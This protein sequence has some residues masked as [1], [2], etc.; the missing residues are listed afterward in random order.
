MLT[1]D[2][3]QIQVDD[4]GYLENLADWQPEVAEQIARE[5]GLELTEAHWEIL[6]LLRQFY[7]EFE[8]SPAMRPLVKYIGINL[9][10][11]KA[12]S[13]YLMQLF[14]ESPAKMASKLA[15]L[16]KPTNCL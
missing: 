14:G 4:E 9:D 2:N 13:I 1:I 12:K 8:L 11:D 10:K 16:P 15:G 5:E 7:Q 3:K 6:N